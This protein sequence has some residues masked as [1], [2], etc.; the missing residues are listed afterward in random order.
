MTQE[1]HDPWALLRQAQGWIGYWPLNKPEAGAEA[2]KKRID[3]ALAEHDAVPPSEEKVDSATPVVE[4]RAD[5]FGRAAMVGNASLSVW[6]WKDGWAWSC[7][8]HGE[9]TGVAK[10]EEAAKSAAI[11]AA[12]GMKCPANSSTPSALAWSRGIDTPDAAR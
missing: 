10:N 8:R 5:G 4:W 12:R 11:A 3:A 7:E 1:N 6:S 2:L 9:T